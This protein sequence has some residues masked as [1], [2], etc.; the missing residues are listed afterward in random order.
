[1]EKPLKII[2]EENP[3]NG[4]YSNSEKG[5]DYNAKLIKEIFEKNKEIKT[6]KI[7]NTSY[8]EY[9]DFMRNNHLQE[10]RD[11]IFNKEVKC[12]ESEEIAKEYVNGLVKLL[13]NYENWF[14]RKTPRYH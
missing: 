2:F 14:R 10:F 8:I 7:L 4:R 3:I 6:I 1:M 9:L 5:K 12:G 13:F 11:E